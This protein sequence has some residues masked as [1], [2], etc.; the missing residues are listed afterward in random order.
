M[1]HSN[2]T[3]LIDYWSARKGDGPAPSRAAIDPAHF[4]DIITQAFMVGRT[5][6]GV[7][8]F[9]LA[10]GLLEDLHRRPL[11]GADFMTLWAV[12]DRPR[13]AAA[14]ESALHRGAALLAQV[15][16]RTV[17]G[18]Q[19]KLE[20]VLAPL[21]SPTGQVDRMLGL[22]Q[23]VSPL[24]RLQNEAIERLFLLDIAFADTG[25]AP[26]SP[27]RIAAVDGRRIA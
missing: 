2:T 9:R 1:S 14:V 11:L 26:P 4:S 17:Q 5:R 7:Y 3:R 24:F 18:H 16:G 15:L 10:G 25:L 27:L 19:A 21:A 8:P 6:T 22:Y 13:I 20:I 12:S 23:P